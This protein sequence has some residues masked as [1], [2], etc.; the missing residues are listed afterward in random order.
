MNAALKFVRPVISLNA[1]HLKSIFKGTLHV[2]L[3]LS[4]T[5]EVYLIG[6]MISTGN[7]DGKTWM[8]MLKYL[9]EACPII[10]KQ[11]SVFP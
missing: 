9:I 4:G 10:S 7:E 6:F 3:V 2:A 8:T 1:A 11:G 5:N